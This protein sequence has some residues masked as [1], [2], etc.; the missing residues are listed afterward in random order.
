MDS[1]TKWVSTRVHLGW[2]LLAA[3]VLVIVIGVAA[4]WQFA[5]QPYN[6]KIITGAGILLAGIGI[7]YL[8]RYGAALKKGGDSARRMAVEERDERSRMIRRGAGNRAYWVSAVLVYLGLI[9][10]SFAANGDL[11]A[12][13]GDVL[14]YYL[15][16]SFIVPF[17]VYAVSIVI[18]ERNS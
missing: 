1:Y 11:P 3:G 17:G 7:S 15:A 5:D 8:V 13:S 2:V 12:L 16:A 4:E 10:A 9:W 14:W 18:D 6:L